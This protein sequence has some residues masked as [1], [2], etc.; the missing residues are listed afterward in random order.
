MKND[1]YGPGGNPIESASSNEVEPVP[2]EIGEVVSLA[3]ERF[4]AN[5]AL[6]VFIYLPMTACSLALEQ[7]S[8][9]LVWLHV[10]RA[11]SRVALAVRV[12][13]VVAALAFTSFFQVGFLRIALNAARSRPVR[14]RMLV[15]G[16]D[17][18]LPMLWTTLFV[19]VATLVGLLLFIVPGLV[20]N[21]GL[22]LAPYYVVDAGLGPVAAIKKSW[23]ATHG[24]KLDLLVLLL[25][26]VALLFFGLLMFGIGIGAAGPVF[27][28][29]QTIVFTRISGRN[30]ALSKES[31]AP[32]PGWPL[33][34]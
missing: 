1:P 13:S 5:W 11:D 9:L 23:A 12:A 14:L 21:L 29:A 17:R 31:L 10:I 34:F 19:Q 24:Q 2:W 33:V 7:A 22:G 32:P 18:M 27:V 6:F 25:T 20:L 4:Q 26:G 30:A 28:L 3:W 15:S 8:E 16:G